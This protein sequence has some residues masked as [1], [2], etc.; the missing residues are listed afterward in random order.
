MRR[1]L[2]FQH[3]PFEP[4]GILNGMLKRAGLRIRY[5]NFNRSPE[6]RPDPMDYH[7]LVILGGPMSAADTA[8]HPHLEF[9]MDAIRDAVEAGMPVLGICLGAQLVAAALGGRVARNPVREI[10]WYAVTPTDAGRADPLF[11]RFDGSERIFQWHRDTFTLP[12]GAVHLAS[13]P[14]C[15]NQAFRFG[16]NVYGLQFHLE[17]DEALINRWLNTPAHQ[18]MLK[19]M[20]PHVDAQRIRDETRR[21]IGRSLS[22]GGALFGEFIER[23][24]GR[25]RRMSLPSR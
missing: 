25:R 4:L 5:V 3:V 20:P 2:V 14:T 24:H 21:R 11:S 16:E 1:V 22:L 15:A 19:R 6:A 18:K 13:S 23:F 7:G 12:R 10:G 8:R 9:E 17:A